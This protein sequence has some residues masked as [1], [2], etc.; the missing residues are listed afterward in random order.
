MSLAYWSYKNTFDRINTIARAQGIVFTL[1]VDDM[2]FSSS[3]PI[4]RNFELA[5]ARLMRLVGHKINPKK[6]KRY[7]PGDTPV[8]TGV[9]TSP[10]GCRVPNRRRRAI[11]DILNR[12]A[13]IDELDPKVI[14]SVLG[15]IQ[16][17]RQIEPHFFQGS[18]LAVRA[19]N[20][21][22]SAS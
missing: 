15:K 13:S 1:W 19:R 10:H 6:T 22:I 20:R 5:V 2:I 11:L 8:I 7:S 14:R 9:A 17:G 16:S 18:Y 3:K 21:K 12:A 4:P